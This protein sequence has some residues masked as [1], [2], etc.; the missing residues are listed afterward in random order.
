MPSFKLLKIQE[1]FSLEDIYGKNIENVVPRIDDPQTTK[2]FLENARKTHKDLHF[3]SIGETDIVKL[4]FEELNQFNDNQAIWLHREKAMIKFHD[5]LMIG[6]SSQKVER[7][8]QLYLRNRVEIKSLR[9]T[10]KHL[11]RLWLSLR[12]NVREMGLEIYLHR[13]ILINTYLNSD[14]LKE[15]NLH[16]MDV[17]DLRSIK[18]IIVQAEIIKVI[19]IKVFGLTRDN[20]VVTIR[21]D[22][23]GSLM[24]YGNHKSETFLKVLELLAISM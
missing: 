12:R 22:R 16:A 10:K 9:F 23:N 15:I 1:T 7:I 19:T 13:I 21:I 18:D 11:W 3:E 8:V 20:K 5:Y 14:H 6:K 4:K 24:I 17:S 2:L